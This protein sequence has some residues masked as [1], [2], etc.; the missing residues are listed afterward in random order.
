VAS[1]LKP[2]APGFQGV[3][4]EV[5]QILRRHRQAVKPEVVFYSFLYTQDVSE[6]GLRTAAVLQILVAA[7]SRLNAI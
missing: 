7:A 2:I 5:G 6:Q 4:D 1:F 3:L